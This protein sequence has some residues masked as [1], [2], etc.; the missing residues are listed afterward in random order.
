MGSAIERD[1]YRVPR[2]FLPMECKAALLTLILVSGSLAGCTGDPDAGGMDEIDIETIQGILNNSTIELI[3]NIS[4]NSEPIMY[5]MSGHFGYYGDDFEY[6]KG[7]WTEY[8]PGSWTWVGT[9]AN[10]IDVVTIHQ[11]EHEMIE[12]YYVAFHGNLNESLG[13]Y[14]ADT[15]YDVGSGG[16]DSTYDWEMNCSNGLHNNLTN[17][18]WNSWASM[19]DMYGDSIG[20]R[21]FPMP[22]QECDYT[23]NFKSNNEMSKIWWTIIF[24]VSELT[25]VTQT[26]T[27]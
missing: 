26:G 21:A 19:P 13:D 2:Q 17:S 4:G 22:G 6:D 20:E 7:V 12:L 5:Y 9:P 11:E 10:W 8:Q 24:T 16:F 18:N 1:V 15:T 14:Q 23:L 3:S 27:P 25:E